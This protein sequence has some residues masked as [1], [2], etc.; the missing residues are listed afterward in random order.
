MADVSVNNAGMT[1]DHAPAKRIDWFKRTT[2]LIT[3]VVIIVGLYF[4]W[5]QAKQLT[6]TIKVATKS[7]NL[8]AWWG[9]SNQFIEVD[10]TLVNH[11]EFMKY[12][13]DG[14][15]IGPDHPDYQ[16]AKAIGITFLDLGES[17]LTFAG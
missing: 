3:L 12:F 9:L 1:C 4:A 14:A 5:D 10:K 16:R 8:A 11:P 7:T 6:Q 17:I 15:N 13:Y 2:D